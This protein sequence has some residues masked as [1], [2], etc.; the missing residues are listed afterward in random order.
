MFPDY[1]VTLISVE[2]NQSTSV[3]NDNAL[4]GNRLERLIYI[5]FFH[6]E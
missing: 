3:L 2:I 6:S 5:C 4:P 1:S